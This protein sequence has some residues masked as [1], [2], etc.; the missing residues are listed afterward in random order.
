MNLRFTEPDVLIRAEPGG[1][2]GHPVPLRG[3]SILDGGN[4][5]AGPDPFEVPQYPVGTMP[6]RNWR[7]PVFDFGT[8]LAPCGLIEYRGEAVPVLKGKIL[9][10]RYSGGKNVI[11]L[12]PGGPESGYAV[13]EA[14][15]NIE[16]LTGF[17]GPLDLTE[18]PPTGRLYVAEFGGERITLL[19]PRPGTA[20]PRVYRQTPLNPP[21]A[22]AARAAQASRPS[23]R[24][25][26][27]PSASRR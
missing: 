20:S 3:E 18:D 25:S 2:Y 8:H 11:A 17:D 19:R 1:Y 14:F 4:P 23:T 5:T 15:T 26:S 27:R 7:L 24:P 10:A 6:E 21:A 16:G 9:V 22:V 12:T 13:T